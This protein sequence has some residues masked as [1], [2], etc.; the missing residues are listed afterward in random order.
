MDTSF[1]T[2]T[3]MGALIVAVVML[4][5]SAGAQVSARANLAD[6]PRAAPAATLPSAPSANPAQT[7]GPRVAPAGIQVQEEARP[8][9]PGPDN[10]L[11]AGQ[12]LAM[13][14][15]GAAG[16]VVGLLV[17]G[18]GGTVLA[19]GGGVIGLIGLYRYIR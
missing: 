4:P 11:N 18:D 3:V 19:L 9:S 6:G 17:G 12:N 16:V 8:V 1:L 5:P 10:N 13:M 7:A 14:G 2:S 15:V